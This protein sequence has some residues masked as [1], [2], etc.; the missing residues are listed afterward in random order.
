MKMLS[1]L[2][3]DDAGFIVSSELILLATIV[4]LG[5][6]TGLTTIRD[7]VVQE[8]G[9]VADA[10]SEIDQSY[11]YS[12]I[13]AHSASTAGSAFLDLNDFCEVGGDVSDQVAGAEPQCIEID[14]IIGTPE[15]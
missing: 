2:L 12:G 14:T 1:R 7:Q 5:L 3:L 9:D 13:T 10:F 11:S 4:V 6:I 8:L 15:G